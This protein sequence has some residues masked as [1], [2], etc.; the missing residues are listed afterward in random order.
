MSPYPAYSGPRGTLFVHVP[1]H[2]YAVST[3]GILNVVAPAAPSA[4]LRSHPS[5]P[6]PTLAPASH[7]R[8]SQCGPHLA[9]HA[10]IVWFLFP[11][12]RVLAWPTYPGEPPLSRLTTFNDPSFPSFFYIQRRSF[13]FD[14]NTIHSFLLLDPRAVLDQHSFLPIDCFKVHP[15]HQPNGSIIPSC[16]TESSVNSRSSPSFQ[17]ASKP[18][19]SRV[20][21]YEAC[22]KLS[23]TGLNPI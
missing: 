16:R 10:S 11:S 15:S 21:T 4:G 20:H 5:P 14:Q 17:P 9:R 1:A 3:S 23:S 2:Y 18:R 12:A 7:S 6:I 19:D 22:S 8:Q 13:S